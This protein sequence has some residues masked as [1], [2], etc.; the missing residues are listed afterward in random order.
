MNFNNMQ[1]AFQITIDKKI[2][3]H[4]IS[5]LPA[6]IRFLEF[7][8]KLGYKAEFNKWRIPQ[9]SCKDNLVKDRKKNSTGNTPK[10]GLLVD[11][12]RPISGFT[13]DGNTARS[14]FSERY[15]HI[16][17]EILGIEKWLVDGL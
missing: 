15:R 2:F 16:F 9:K 4:G 6:W 13:N 7:L 5:L 8:M 17:A 14:L 3:K 11:V 12:V 10:L 1:A